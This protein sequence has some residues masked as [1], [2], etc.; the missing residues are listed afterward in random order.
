MSTEPV[1]STGST[2]DND[3]MTDHHEPVP[4]RWRKPGG[5]TVDEFFE[6]PD[7]PPHTELIDGELVLVSPQRLF[8]MMVIRQ[9]EQALLE[10]VPAHLAVIREM[11]VVIGRRNAPEPDLSLVPVEALG[12]LD[13]TRYPTEVVLLAAEVES[14]DSI[15][16]DRVRKLNLYAEGGIR[17]YWRIERQNDQPVV[18]VYE[19]DPAA[20]AYRLTGV[21]RDRLKLAIPF[22]LDID[23]TLTHP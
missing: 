8:H 6:L 22:D 11:N 15:K 2:N 23:L 5:Y 7:L 21:H 12:D 16:R 17:H 3:A 18:H 1:Y 14:P 19:L 10:S 4:D 13:D 20:R 9:L